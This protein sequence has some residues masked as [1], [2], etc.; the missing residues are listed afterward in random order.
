[1]PT[2]HFSSDLLTYT[3][4][5]ETLA[6]EAPRIHELKQSLGRRFPGLAERLD[7]MAV[8]IDGEIYNDADY[9]AVG[10]ATEIHFVP[11]TVGG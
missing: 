11:R 5:L 8:A 9:R 1:M 10:A 2:V 7:G 4:G 6:I 3:G